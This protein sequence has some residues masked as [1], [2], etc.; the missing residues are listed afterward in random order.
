MPATKDDSISINKYISASGF[1]SRR[2]ADKLIE[3]FRVTINDELAMPGT[4]VQPGDQ[5]AV[6]GEN[7]KSKKKAIYL[8]FNKPPGITSTTDLK[9]KS[10]IISYINFPKRI[11][12]VGRLDKDSDGLIFLTNDGDIV[13]KILRA[14]NNH[15]KEYIVTVDKSI[16][17]S[18]VHKMANGIPVLGTVT[19]KCFVRQEGNRKFRI[20][21]TQGL[22]RQIRRMCEFLGYEVRTLTRVRIMHITLGNLPSGKTRYFTAPEIDQL[23]E[24]VASSSKTVEAPSAKI[25]PRKKRK[26]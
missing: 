1:C 3:A 19:K 25:K 16:D 23:N 12:P 17:A 15:E 10:N 4:R 21:L 7:I 8:A 14:S 22:N 26:G 18:F 9:D 20:V 2:E 11:F 5:V 13:N 24:L 6:D